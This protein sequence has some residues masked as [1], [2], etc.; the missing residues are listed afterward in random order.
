MSN[1][2]PH[3][4]WN[5]VKLDPNGISVEVMEN[6]ERMAQWLE[7]VRVWCGFPLKINSWYRSPSHPLE[8]VKDEPGVHATGLAVDIQCTDGG[9]RLKIVKAAI[10]NHV[11][12]IGVGPNFIHLDLGEPT[13][14]RPRPW[15][16]T[17]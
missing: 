15:M 12:G 11:R 2:T 9:R 6:A 8:R 5:E 10:H 13:K 14:R 16:W 7:H 4:T 3:F 1:I 17:Y